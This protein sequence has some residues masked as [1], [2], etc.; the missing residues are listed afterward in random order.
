MRV[1][2]LS[3]ALGLGACGDEL[4]TCNAPAANEL[5]YGRTG[6]VA[7][8][9]QALTHDSCGN[10]AFCHSSAAKGRNRFG[11]PAKLDFDMLPS[12]K[13]LRLLRDTA[14]SSWSLVRDG[15]MPPSGLGST[16]V[17]N[18]DWIASR[19]RNAE[20][21]RLPTLATEAGMAAFRNWLACGAPV[22]TGQE[23]ASAAPPVGLV[24]SDGSAPAFSALHAQ[25]LVPYCATA[26]CHNTASAAAGLALEDS[27][28]AGKALKKLG[29]CGELVVPGSS[30][31]SGLMEKLEKSAPSCGG[32]MPPGTP[33]S[34]TLIDAVRA[35]IDAGAEIDSCS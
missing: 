9:G 20:A 21:A 22:V 30:S 25:V 3:F 11:A 35:W 6:L 19:D 29:L 7:T 18:G 10:G 8:K 4:G 12:P 27:C 28:L 34:S 23:S 1:A 14:E 5:V 2:A 26:G 33:L 15:H 31:A 24:P 32:P 17:G 16:V 13:G